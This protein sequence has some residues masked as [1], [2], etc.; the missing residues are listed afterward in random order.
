MF[1]IH[2][3]TRSLSKNISKIIYQLLTDIVITADTIS[4]TKQ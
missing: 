4:E 3:Y 2:L 1:I